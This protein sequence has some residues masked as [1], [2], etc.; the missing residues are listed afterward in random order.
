MKKSDVVIVVALGVLLLLPFASAGFFNWITGKAPDSNPTNVYVPLGNTVPQIISVDLVSPPSPGP[1]EGTTTTVTISFTVYDHDDYV[2]V[3]TSGGYSLS[4]SK[5]GP[6][7]A[8]SCSPGSGSGKTQSFTCTVAMDYYDSTGSWGISTAAR[9]MSGVTATNTTQ[10]F[11]YG[12]LRAFTITPDN[13]TWG[14]LYP[15]DINVNSTNHPTILTNT[16]NQQSAVELN[17]RD[18]KG[19][20]YNTYK[21]NANDFKV[22]GTDSDQCSRV[23]L[24]HAADVRVR[25]LDNTNLTLNYGAPPQI[26]NVYYCL[27]VVNETL[28]K[29]NYTTSG[30]G[31]WTIK[32]V[33]P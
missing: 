33:A 9:D 6:S 17:A 11:G 27:T 14:T 16:G 19:D 28:I 20:T 22:S 23:A 3:D 12:T 4:V 8:G 15:G 5:G 10:T 26:A 30:N 24:S 25:N 21:I 32:V 2:D 29:Q 31:A 13:L 18:L 7:H 1:T